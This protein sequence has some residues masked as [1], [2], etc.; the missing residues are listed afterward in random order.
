MPSTFV[1]KSAQQTY[2][3]SA[4]GI[5]PKI[6]DPAG[7]RHVDYRILKNIALH[8]IVR[9]GIELIIGIVSK[10][11]WHVSINENSVHYQKYTPDELETMR[12]AMQVNLDEFADEILNIALRNL[13]IYGWQAFER[14]I[15]WN[16]ESEFFRV[17]ELKPILQDFTYIL[18]DDAGNYAGIRNIAPTGGSQV[19]IPASEVLLFN[20]DVV[21]QNWYGTPLLLSAVDP[22]LELCKLDKY[23]DK[24]LDRI[25]S[26]SAV[27]KYPVGT[28]T[29]DDGTVVSNKDIAK[30]LSEGLVNNSV[31][32]IP[33]TLRRERDL[34]TPESPAWE[35]EF[36]NPHNSTVGT[37][38]SENRDHF[39]SL[40]INSLGLPARVVLDG[41][42]GSYSS[43][44]TYREATYDILQTHLNRFVKVINK[45]FID[46]MLSLNYGA[47]GLL[48]IVPEPLNDDSLQNLFRLFAQIK[49]DPNVDKKAVFERL[50]IPDTDKTDKFVAV[51]PVLPEP[52]PEPKMSGDWLSVDNLALRLGMTPGTIKSQLKRYKG[53]EPEYPGIWRG[54]DNRLRLNSTCV[55]EVFGVEY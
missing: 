44:Q 37:L 12:L 17:K 45:Q 47:E 8:P 28:E 52:E 50:G 4:G 49:D 21:G 31:V 55:K 40:L 39:E 1:A 34:A 36:V 26:V 7:H 3:K 5:L 14:I 19:D 25:S 9:L 32:A 18:T 10:V 15:E 46:P 41:Q 11:A 23:N 6:L 13:I 22:Y 33:N 38:F 48:R 35:I 24:F 53:L 20:I 42:Y 51:E 30:D 29:L 16:S 27:I 2:A 43:N 54:S